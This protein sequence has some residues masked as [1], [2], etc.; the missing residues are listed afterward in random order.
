[1]PPHP[2][3]AVDQLPIIN[4]IVAWGLAHY[5]KP[6]YPMQTGIVNRRYKDIPAGNTCPEKQ[7]HN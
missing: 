6:K 2:I 5:Y 4:K 7:S 1:M 3:Q